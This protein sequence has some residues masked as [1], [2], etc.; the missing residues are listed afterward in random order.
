M[1]SHDHDT[2]RDPIDTDRAQR[3]Q[4]RPWLA[5]GITVDTAHHQIT[6]PDERA[7]I[8]ARF[9][10]WRAQIAAGDPKMQADD[11]R[12]EQLAR[13]HSDDTYDADARSD[14]AGDG[15]IVGDDGSGRP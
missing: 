12:R 14:G 6:G 8:V 15:E 9:V 4:D 13:W 10:A 3:L 5:Q 11:E 1:T 7:E 2:T